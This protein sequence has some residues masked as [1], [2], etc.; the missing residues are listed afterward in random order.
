MESAVV[1]VRVR[2]GVVP[3]T[4]E[5]AIVRAVVRVTAADQGNRVPENAK[6]LYARYGVCALPDGKDTSRHVCLR[7]N[8]M[9]KSIVDCVQ[10]L[11]LSIRKKMN[12]GIASPVTP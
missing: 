10:V 3:V 5:A 9:V 11:L 2:R 6:A 1:P 12:G 8:D 4:V 7:I